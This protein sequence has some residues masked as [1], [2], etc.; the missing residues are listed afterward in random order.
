MTA[1]GTIVTAGAPILAQELTLPTLTAARTFAAEPFSRIRGVVEL[2]GGRL[3]VADQNEE[4]VYLVDL[5]RQ[6]RLPVGTRGGGPGEY[7]SPTSLYPFRGDS[8][9][10]VDIQNSRIAVMSPDGKIG[11]TE[12]LFGPGVTVPAAAD[13]LG[14]RYWDGVTSVRKSAHQI[15]SASHAP[16]I[17]YGSTSRSADTIAYLTVPNTGANPFPDW[18][19][20]AVGPRGRIAIVRNQEG[21]RLDWVE[22][23]GTILHGQPV[24]GFEPIRLNVDDRRVLSEGEGGNKAARFRM[25]GGGSNRPPSVDLPKHFPPARWGRVWVTYDG[26]ALVERSQHLSENRPLFDV[27]DERGNRTRG[28]RLPE[29]R[30]LLGTGPSGLFAARE[31]E[32]GFLWLEVYTLH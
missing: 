19:Q 10:L 32:L 15:S 14:N 5:E 6:E 9:L 21:Y 20:W 18:D 7:K 31:D 29:G 23:D 25:N 3:L 24:D 17:R 8:T 22:T 2:P 28:F 26:L 30:Q 1:L 4:T 12:P 16:L 11:R 13:H 27:F